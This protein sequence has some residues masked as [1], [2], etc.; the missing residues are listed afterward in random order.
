MASA[1]DYLSILQPSEEDRKAAM[2]RALMMAA[3][4]AFAA[5]DGR[6]FSS[7]LGSTMFS[8]LKGYDDSMTSS[9]AARKDQFTSRKEAFDLA[10]QDRAVKDRE[11]LAKAMQDAQGAPQQPFQPGSVQ[12]PAFSPPTNAGLPAPPMPDPRAQ[13]RTMLQTTID[14]LVSQ[15]RGDLAGPLQDQLLKLQPEL[16]E[17]KT[18]TDPKSGKRVTV[19]F[20]KDGT[21]EVVPYAPDAEKLHFTDTG[22]SVQGVDPFTAQPVG[23]AVR[24]T[25]TPGEI[26]S[27]TRGYAGLNL[28]RDQFNRGRQ[29]YDPERGGIVNLDTGGMTPVTQGGAPVAPKMPD[30]QKRELMGIDKQMAQVQGAME[31]VKATPSAFGMRRGMAT[32]AG[33]IPE[34]VAGRMDSD[35]ERQARSYVF[36]IVS[37]VINE[38]AG[39]AQ[40]KQELARLRSFLPGEMDAPDQIQS[41]LEGF[42]K[43]LSDSRGGVAAPITAA[44]PQP[45]TLD[46]PL[47]VTDPTG[48]VHTFP[49][50]MQADAFRKA[51]GL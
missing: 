29:A 18:L 9:R 26:D 42:Q 48:K 46:S 15:G 22:G 14:K 7:I 24:K 23:G 2:T 1:D 27:S 11:A 35:P 21:Q 19:N 28:Q 41:K 43:Y 12:S 6:P 4:Q 31:A 38:R 37:S 44:P 40:S 8:G 16:K 25:M 49:T 50:K 5:N 39:A 3:A 45:K 47:S 20:F 13:R 51:A 33:S 36:N 32:M 17:T 30:A 10:Q 34:S